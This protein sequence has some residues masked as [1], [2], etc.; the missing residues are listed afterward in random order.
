[1]NHARNLRLLLPP[2]SE[3]PSNESP[4]KLYRVTALLIPTTWKFNTTRNPIVIPTAQCI[5]VQGACETGIY[6]NLYFKRL[7]GRR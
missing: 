2:H 6:D 7:I 4:F 1:M 3:Q 5:T